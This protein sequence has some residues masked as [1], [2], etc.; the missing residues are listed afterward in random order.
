MYTL[1][2]YTYSYYYILYITYALLYY[3][4]LLQQVVKRDY[5]FKSFEQAASPMT[6]SQF[7]HRYHNNQYNHN[8]QN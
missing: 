1:T 4:I 2:D 3:Y 6:D 5:A 7:L 8:N